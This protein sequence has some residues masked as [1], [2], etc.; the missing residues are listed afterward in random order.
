MDEKT[1][2]IVLRWL[3]LEEKLL[4]EDAVHRD[5]ILPEEEKFLALAIDLLDYLKSAWQELYPAPEVPI[6]E[7]QQF[8][9]EMREL[10]EQCEN[11]D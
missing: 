10:D 3:E 8:E 7:S 11:C 1:T 6:T 5:R 4:I 2:E 9:V